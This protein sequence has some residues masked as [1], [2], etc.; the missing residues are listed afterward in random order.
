MPKAPFFNPDGTS[1]GAHALRTATWMG[2]LRPHGVEVDIPA[3][4]LISTHEP[5]EAG[6][7]FVLGTSPTRRCTTSWIGRGEGC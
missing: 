6:A 1:T 4:G 2:V 7:G 3:V 5:G